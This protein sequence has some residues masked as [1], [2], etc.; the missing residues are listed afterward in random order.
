VLILWD[1]LFGTFSRE[2]E[3]EPVVY[4]LTKNLER[5]DPWTV[6]VHGYRELWAD[7]RRAS[8]PVDRLRYCLR[9]PGWSHD[10]PDHRAST[11]RARWLGE[12]ADGGGEI[13]A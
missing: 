8:S 5:D 13:Q 2:T 7:L 12:A 6:L 11:L 4:G 3:L 9:P 10:G 1:R